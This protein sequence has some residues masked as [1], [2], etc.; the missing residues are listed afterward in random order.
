M[1]RS[2]IYAEE[3]LTPQYLKP[4]NKQPLLKHQL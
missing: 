2:P 3:N 4:E 1:Y